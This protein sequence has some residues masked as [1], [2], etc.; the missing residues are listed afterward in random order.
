MGDIDPDVQPH[1]DKLTA[2]IAEANAAAATAAKAATDAAELAARAQ[3]GVDQ[4]GG[5]VAELGTRVSKLEKPTTTPPPAPTPERFE[6]VDFARNDAGSL[7]ATGS[8]IGKGSTLTTY[9]VKPGSSTKTPPT[10]G[11]NPLRVVRVGGTS[12][13]LQA[14][15]KVQGVTVEGYAGHNTHGLTVGYVAGAV[16]SDVAVIGAKGSGS[17]PPA[18]TFG[19]EVWNAT[20]VTVS[21]CVVDGLGGA[22]TLFGL[23]SVDGAVVSKLK[24]TGTKVAFGTA[25]WQCGNVVYRDCDLRGVRRAMNFEQCYGSIT[26]ERVDLRD[27]LS[28]RTT[29]PDIV[30][31]TAGYTPGRGPLAGV[32]QTSAKVRIIDPVWDRAKGPL[33]VG[34]PTPGGNYAAAGNRPHTQRAED[35]TVVIDGQTFTGPV[36]N[37]LVKIGNY[38]SG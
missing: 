10:T 28:A 1:L 38:W 20:N 9:A 22:G 2:D 32:N 8:L 21:D 35:V 34:V 14:G 19:L 3:L 23:N 31:A 15:V 29:G 33:V 24:A 17:S 13:A 6:A 27:R 18:E 26:I 30:V 7:I 25:T 12:G 37:S 5:T 16:V 36:N 4:L 11:T